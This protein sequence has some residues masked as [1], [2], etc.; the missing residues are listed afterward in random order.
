MKRTFLPLLLLLAVPA[1]G[2]AEKP[3]RAAVQ[4][5]ETKPAPAV[6]S[7][8]REAAARTRNTL[9]RLAT[10]CPDKKCDPADLEL[11]ANAEKRYVEACRACSTEER[12][13]EDRAK[14]RDNTSKRFGPCD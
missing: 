13:E 5:K 11:I 10:V 7:K 1:A 6:D 12:C 3:A 2:A 9:R 8:L 4:K 14:I